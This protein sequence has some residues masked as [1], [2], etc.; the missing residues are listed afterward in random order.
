MARVSRS[1]ALLWSP[2]ESPIIGCR[3]ESSWAWIWKVF[4]VLTC[5]VRAGIA[6]PAASCQIGQVLQLPSIA[7]LSCQV[8]I[9]YAK[10]GARTPNLHHIRDLSRQ[11]KQNATIAQECPPMEPCSH[12]SYTIEIYTLNA[13]IDR[14]SIVFRVFGQLF[15]RS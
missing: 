15:Y 7:V 2:D 8:S 6:P 1:Q 4:A 14:R 10:V 5:E 11:F 13:V 12:Y 3:D 9:F